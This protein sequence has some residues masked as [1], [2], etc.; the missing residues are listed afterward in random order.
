MQYA[1]FEATLGKLK[2][3]GEA[4]TAQFAGLNKSDN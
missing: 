1:K 2:S 3:I 4:M